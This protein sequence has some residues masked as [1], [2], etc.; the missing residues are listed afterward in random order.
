M[1][2][3][4]REFLNFSEKMSFIERAFI[5]GGAVRDMILGKETKDIDI[6]IKGNAIDI[7]KEFAHIIYGSFVLLDEEFGVA[8]IVKNNYCID[9]SQLRGDSI[10]YDLSER[11]LTINSMAIPLAVL[12]SYLSNIKPFLIDPYNGQG[13]L[14]NRIIRIVSEDNLIKDPLRILRIYRFAGTLGFSIDERTRNSAKGLSHL[15]KTVSME[16]ITEELKYIIALDN[17]YKT[18]LLLF[19]DGILENIFPEGGNIVQGLELYK[20]IEECL[21]NPTFS[22]IYSQFSRE[23]FKKICLKFS[24]LFSEPEIAKSSAIRLKLSKK[25]IEFIYKMA[26][27][28]NR[29]LDLYR[30]GIKN[31]GI[32]LLSILKEFKDDIYPL[33]ILTISNNPNT[34]SFCL[35]IYTYY[36]NIF[37]QRMGLLPLITGN[38]LIKEFN[39]KPSPI[40][41]DLLTTVEDMVLEGRINS[42]DEALGVVRDIINK[43][44]NR[45]LI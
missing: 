22:P 2:Y 27:N 9:I 14:F 8:R 11:D 17:S 45:Q 20:N 32:E 18:I 6:A 1:H 26:L 13:D 37:K 41:K 35:E 12:K 19:D 31:S 7:A 36:N 25:E 43:Q 40:F 42:K 23:P 30:K 44:S 28:R 10:Y 3:I 16:R 34:V 38:D 29:I 39:L 5:V 33:L 21:N 24:S 15:I 4:L